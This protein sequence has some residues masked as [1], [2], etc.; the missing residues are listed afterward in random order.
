MVYIAPTERLITTTVTS[1][2]SLFLSIVHLFE[3]SSLVWS[4]VFLAQG[5]QILVQIHYQDLDME[6]ELSKSM[7]LNTVLKYDCKFP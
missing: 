7:D 4:V 3:C 6:I 2:N 5:I 1:L